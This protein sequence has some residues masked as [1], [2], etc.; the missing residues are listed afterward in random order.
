M[1]GAPPDAEPYARHALAL[2]WLFGLPGAPLLYYGDEY[3]EWG[4]ADP[5]NRAFW[6]GDG[7]L[8][9]NE[10]AVLDRTR[11]LG[12]ARRELVA[13][14][15]GAYR[16]LHATENFL[17]FARETKDG[18]V[19]IVA[20]SRDAGPT[21]T[22][23]TLPLTLPLTNGTALSDRR[24]GAAVTVTGGKLSISLPGRGAAILAP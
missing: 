7:T 20:L 22:E 3:G 19:A 16:S 13:L 5:G 18:K 9:A 1:A 6:R 17:A 11:K 24:G 23:V 2:S 21:T 10:A 8:S 4:G 14:R 15:R 12:A